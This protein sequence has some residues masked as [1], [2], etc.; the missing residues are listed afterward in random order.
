MLIFFRTLSVAFIIA[1]ISIIVF[2]RANE[3]RPGIEAMG[4][5]MLIP[6]VLGIPVFLLTF[7]M[8][9]VRRRGQGLRMEREL[10]IRIGKRRQLPLRQFL[11]V[12]ILMYAG[13]GTLDTTMSAISVVRFGRNEARLVYTF[14]YIFS[15]CVGGF[16]LIQQLRRQSIIYGPLTVLSLFLLFLIQF[17]SYMFEPLKAASGCLLA[18][19]AVVSALLWWDTRPIKK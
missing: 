2:V 12:A 4:F 17:Q 10:T 5:V 16:L 18:A 1:I 7:I 8:E 15:Y 9:L 11:V 19:T 3:G 13:F 14:L 6:L